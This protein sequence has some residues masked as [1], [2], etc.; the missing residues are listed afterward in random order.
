MPVRTLCKC[1]ATEGPRPLRRSAGRVPSVRR[2]RGLSQT[3]SVADGGTARGGY[4]GGR[5][6]AARSRRSRNR[7]P[8]EDDGRQAGGRGVFEHLEEAIQYFDPPSAPVPPRKK[9]DQ[10]PWARRMFEALLDPSSIQWMLTLGGG[11]MVLGLIIWLTSLGIFKNPLVVAVA[12][13]IG[14]LVI[15]GAGWYVALETRYKMAGQ[16]LT[17]LGCVVLPLN[18]WYYH[19]QGLITL[20]G[21]LWQAGLACCLLYAATVYVLRDPLFMYAVEV[22]VSL[23][24]LLLLGSF[25]H[26][27]TAVYASLVFMGLALVS[28]HAER[29]FAPDA[30]DVHAPQV[31]LAAVLVRAR[32]NSAI[33]LL[34]RCSAR[35]LYWLFEPALKLFGMRLGREL[36]GDPLRAGRGPVAGWRVRLRL[37]RPRG[38]PHRR[39]RVPGGVLCR[40]GASDADRRIRDQPGDADRRAGRHGAGRR[41]RRSVFG[42]RRTGTRTRAPAA[43]LDPQLPADRAGR[44]ASS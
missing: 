25:G 38:P 32:R 2:H 13:G 24:M 1:G 20:E 7:Q 30:E 23:T 17:F 14:S 4:G 42:G 22:G 37:Q 9:K 34:I 6:T 27:D 35:A 33:S 8:P 11:L 36:P 29:A 41:L 19:A 16:A 12:M 43:G 10:T 44:L 15:L 28:I 18:L 40:H 26:A 39:V 21:R 5:I 31:W 3:R